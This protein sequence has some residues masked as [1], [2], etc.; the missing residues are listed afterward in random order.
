[1]IG[2]ASLSNATRPSFR[3]KS[4][5]CKNRN[6]NETFLGNAKKSMSPFFTDLRISVQ[7]QGRG[8]SVFSEKIVNVATKI[9]STFFT[10]FLPKISDPYFSQTLIYKFIVPTFFRNFSLS[11]SLK[12]EDQFRNRKL[13][14]FRL[15]PIL[16]GS[17]LRPNIF[18]II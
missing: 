12:T 1:V 8:S 17:S 5:I 18:I 13:K 14:K 4:E 10:I 3:S 6:G 9:L 16:D 2:W 7:L 11:F 15:F